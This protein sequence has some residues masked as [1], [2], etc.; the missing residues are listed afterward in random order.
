M[1]ANIHDEREV[2]IQKLSSLRNKGV[3]PYPAQVSRT[4]TIGE[5]LQSFEAWSAEAKVITIA[6]RI[7]LLRRHGGLSFA[8]VEDETGT[9]QLMLSKQEL[10]VES[11]ELLKEVDVADFIAATG[12]LI[13]SKTGEKTLQAANWTMLSKALLPLPEKF[14]GLKNE[15][16][17]YRRRYVDLI[18]NQ[19]V[20]DFFRLRSRFIATMR[21]F[22]TREGFMEVE[23]PVLE[24]IPGG[25]EAEPF[26]THH[27]TLDI[28]L[29]LRISLELHL[30]R[31]IVG[32]YDKVFEIGKVFRNEGMSTQH[33]QEF[34]EM[35]FYWAYAD[36]EKLMKLVQSLYQE[37]IQKTFGTLDIPYQDT[38][39]H[40]GGEWP[41]V[42]YFELLREHAGIDLD[43][44]KTADELRQA[45]IE[46]KIPL[47]M[48]PK[49]GLGRLIDQLYKKTVRPKL[50]QPCFLVNHP[51][52]VSP[53]AKRH[54]TQPNKVERHQVLIVGAEL[55]NGFSEL[56]D[57]LDQRTRF[58]EQM[59][60]R[61]AGD[62]EAQMI[63]NDFLQALEH[64]MP[65]TAGFGVGID[66][67]LAVLT[68]KPSIR[69]TVFFPTMRPEQETD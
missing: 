29:Y 26:V 38:V 69:D 64:G 54:A 43:V 10:G 68:N 55:G 11:Y 22:L 30:K 42:D 58:E 50:I 46:K 57:P 1:Q 7:R 59:S 49:A 21:D 23:T 63:D 56:N 15:E 20:K 41:R 45:I 66:R 31:L 37:M 5:T 51:V 3:D 60:L 35:E 24:H 32:G 18:V 16:E 47:K 9:I 62:K 27:N 44:I 40:F 8:R 67:L 53:L 19:D 4:A 39:L 28:D 25:A 2:R 52:A 61:E 6:G 12:K 48:D 14:H 17:R 13:V 36:N 34:T 33:L 65:P